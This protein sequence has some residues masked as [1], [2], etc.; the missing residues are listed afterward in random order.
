[1]PCNGVRLQTAVCA[2]GPLPYHGCATVGATLALA[3]FYCPLTWSVP[4]WNLHRVTESVLDMAG[5]WT[6]RSKSLPR[7]DSLR[8]FLTGPLRC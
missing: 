2:I 7:N 3:T 8:E 5:E 1:M 6:H 4:Y